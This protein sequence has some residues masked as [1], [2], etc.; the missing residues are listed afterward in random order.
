MVV[1]GLVE[2]R[3]SIN[4]LLKFLMNEELDPNAVQ[5]AEDPEFPILIKGNVLP[6]NGTLIFR[7]YFPM[8]SKVYNSDF[9]GCEFKGN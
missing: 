5:R 2:A 7:W 8:G 9:V 4:R 1:S 6:G 3:V